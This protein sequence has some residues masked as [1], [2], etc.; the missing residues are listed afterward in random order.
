MANTALLSIIFGSTKS[1]NPTNKHISIT[2]HKPRFV[3]FTT[4][5][6]SPISYAVSD[7]HQPNSNAVQHGYDEK[8]RCTTAHIILI[9]III[10]IIII[11][12]PDDV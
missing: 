3:N 4:D 2:V 5:F 8:F 1:N 12:Y 11:M 6:S 7:L 9:I 10:I